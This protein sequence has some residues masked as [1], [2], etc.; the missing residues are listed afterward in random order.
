MYVF[1]GTGTSWCFY[2]DL[3]AF[4]IVSRAWRQVQFSGSSPSPRCFHTAVVEGGRLFI[5]GGARL[6]RD[7]WD[8]FNHLYQFV[9][10]DPTLLETGLPPSSTLQGDMKNLLESG[11]FSDVT[12]IVEGR[13]VRNGIDG[14]PF[15]SRHRLDSCVCCRQLA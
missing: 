12:F 2:N 1:G 15:S 13:K 6:T 8:Y 10:E 4:D 7:A 9:I 11:D 5:F 3:H 14:T